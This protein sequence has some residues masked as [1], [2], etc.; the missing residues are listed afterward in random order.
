MSTL[1]LDRCSSFSPTLWHLDLSLRD[2]RHD[3]CVFR[4]L[5][6]RNKPP[7]GNRRATLPNTKEGRKTDGLRR[8]V[9]QLQAIEELEEVAYG[10]QAC[11]LFQ[12]RHR[13]P[14]NVRRNVAATGRKSRD[15]SIPYQ[16]SAT[17]IHVTTN[18]QTTGRAG[19]KL[20]PCEW[21]SSHSG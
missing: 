8:P 7:T 13:H 19:V 11:T 15:S 4:P 6:R 14:P 1:W 21:G 9:A 20:A 2:R 3:A 10:R 16:R 18:D 12:W 5:Q 17:I